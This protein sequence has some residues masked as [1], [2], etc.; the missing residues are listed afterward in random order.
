MLPERMSSSRR[1]ATICSEVSP[2]GIV[3]DAPRR[4]RRHG[5]DD[6]A[7]AGVGFELIFAGLEIVARLK[8]KH[9]ADKDPRLVDYP[10]RISTS[11]MS[12][13]PEPRGILTT[14]SSAS[15]PGASKRCLPVTRANAATTATTNKSD[16]RVADDDKR[17][18]RPFGA[19]AWR[20]LDRVRF[21]GGARTARC[22]VF[23]R[24]AS[25]SAVDERL[26]Y[27]RIS[28]AGAGHRLASGPGPLPGAGPMRRRD[29][30]LRPAAL[31]LA[32]SWLRDRRPRRKPCH[33]LPQGAAVAAS[34][35]WL[36]L[37]WRRAQPLSGE[38]RLAGFARPGFTTFG[39]AGGGAFGAAEA[40]PRRA[41]PRGGRSRRA[42]ARQQT[43][44]H[45]TGE[46]CRSP[47]PIRS[48][49]CAC[50]ARRCPS[51]ERTAAPRH[52]RTSK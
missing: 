43:A 15:G 38:A 46:L 19:T 47:P 32:I 21:E 9:A 16:D 24:L 41:F 44:D 45:S 5:G 13:M 48:A 51:A 27:R 11:E 17:M 52:R 30:R 42:A 18:P 2:S 33:P 40:R 10:S 22:Q 1:R 8:R 35:R 34:L 49:C 14:L 37:A 6:V 50:S 39:A 7:Q 28:R 20:H 26:G 31:A 29:S 12:R 36:D 25:G 3:S 23:V 4:D